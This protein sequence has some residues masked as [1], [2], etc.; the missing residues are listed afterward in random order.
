MYLTYPFVP[1][2]SLLSILFDTS[3]IGVVKNIKNTK[4]IIETKIPINEKLLKIDKENLIKAKNYL[5]TTIL[6]KTTKS[7]NIIKNKLFNNENKKK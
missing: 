2:I 5:K 3:K 6:N 1:G 7:T 4:N